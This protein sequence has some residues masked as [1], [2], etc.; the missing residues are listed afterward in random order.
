[1]AS[2]G[3][4][5][6][7]LARSKGCGVVATKYIMRRLISV[8]WTLNV[9]LKSLDPTL[10]VIRHSCLGSL[11]PHQSVNDC[12]VHT[13]FVHNHS[14]TILGH[15]FLP[16]DNWKNKIKK[17]KRRRYFFLVRFY[18]KYTPKQRNHWWLNLGVANAYHHY[19]SIVHIL[20]IHCTLSRQH[21]EPLLGFTWIWFSVQ[22]LIPKRTRRCK[23]FTQ[24]RF[25]LGGINRPRTGVAMPGTIPSARL[26]SNRSKSPKYLKSNG[27]WLWNEIEPQET[28][29]KKP[30]NYNLTRINRGVACITP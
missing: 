2:Y 28:F 30:W 13:Y 20:H 22:L 6:V 21:P 10:W 29:R 5:I 19:I 1:M 23:C 16:S 9:S 8:V 18:C 11:E 25:F 24:S 3:L 7:L 14:L 12:S 17:R 27:V 4:D 15:L 26:I